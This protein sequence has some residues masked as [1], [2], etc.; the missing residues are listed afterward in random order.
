MPSVCSRCKDWACPRSVSPFSSHT[1]FEEI[2]NL[3]SYLFRGC[4]KCP[5]GNTKRGKRIC[6]PLPSIVHHKTSHISEDACFA[7]MQIDLSVR[8]WIGTFAALAADAI[9][10][11]SRT[12]SFPADL[13]GGNLR[14]PPL[15]ENRLN[16]STSAA[17]KQSKSKIATNCAAFSNAGFFRPHISSSCFYQLSRFFPNNHARKTQLHS[18]QSAPYFTYCNM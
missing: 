1:R 11:S 18:R 6:V 13:T 5:D 15:T 10:I 17:R 12:M 3:S 4:E 14:Q 16:N 9:P 2:K 7:A 8:G